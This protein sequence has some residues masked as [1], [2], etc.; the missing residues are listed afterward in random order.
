MYDENET[1]IPESTKKE[2]ETCGSFA[3]TSHYKIY[4]HRA[5]ELFDED[6]KGMR[7][8]GGEREQNACSTEANV[9]HQKALGLF[10]D[11][12]KG[13]PKTGDTKPFTAKEVMVAQIQE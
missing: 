9:L 6:G 11:F 1:S 8:V 3:V 5:G 13:S 4:G 7:F 2:K 10:R 12:S